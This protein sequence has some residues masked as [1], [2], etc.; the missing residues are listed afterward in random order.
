MISIP[1]EREAAQTAAS[2]F[3]AAGGAFFAFCLWWALTEARRARSSV[4]IL[5][6]A[7]G[8]IA[9][10]EESWIN[11]LIKLWYP[12]DSPLVAFTALGHPQPLYVHLVYPGFVGLGAYVTYRGLVRD[13]SGGALW[14]TFLGIAV[15]D[16]LFELPATAG[17]VFSYYGPQPFQL[18]DAGWPVWVAFING[19]GPVLA[20]WLIYTIEP[21]LRGR[22]RLLLAL[23]PPF[24]YAAVYGAAGWPTYTLLNSDVP[25]AARW[26][27]A[28]VTIGLCFAIVRLVHASLRPAPRSAGAGAEGSVTTT[29]IEAAPVAAA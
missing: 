4:A 23:M 11:L 8:L 16:A 1:I 10:L 20:G 6:F 18:F 19:A 9:S 13:P 29:T 26:L 25:M 15:L 14:K 12:T 2:A 3:T 24:A 28:L 22:E 27:G 17:D 7:G 5:A 21:R